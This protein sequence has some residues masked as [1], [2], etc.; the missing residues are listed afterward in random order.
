MGGKC[1][2]LLLHTGMDCMW[3]HMSV[4]THACVSMCTRSFVGSSCLW[5]D[6]SIYI[7]VCLGQGTENPWS[8]CVSGRRFIHL[9]GRSHSLSKKRRPGDPQ[10]PMRGVIDSNSNRSSLLTQSI[11]FVHCQAVAVEHTQLV[12]P[13]TFP[14]GF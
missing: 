1:L 12:L 11:H 9:G 8:C 4:L 7:N 3:L 5:Y 13:R 14:F 6:L 10:S 2:L